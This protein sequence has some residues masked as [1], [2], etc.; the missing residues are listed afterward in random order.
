M[1]DE[2]SNVGGS[3]LGVAG[4]LQDAVKDMKAI[5]NTPKS[6]LTGFVVMDFFIFDQL[7]LAYPD[8]AR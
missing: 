8:I 6:A 2:C 1:L 3:I 5:K 4:P 7:P